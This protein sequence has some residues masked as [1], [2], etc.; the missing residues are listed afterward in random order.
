MAKKDKKGLEAELSLPRLSDV[1]ET[2][3]AELHAA[4]I[5]VA[6]EAIDRFTNIFKD[7][8]SR[9]EHIVYPAMLIMAFAFAFG[10]FLMF[11]LSNDMRR[12]S[13]GF[14]P[15]MGVHMTS[16]V[17]S[18]EKLSNSIHAMQQEMMIIAKVMQRMDKKLTAMGELT[19]MSQQVRI[20]N[21]RMLVMNGHM[22]G[23]NRQMGTMNARMGRM[24]HSVARMDNAVGRPMSFV[25]S[26]MPW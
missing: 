16:L 10:F 4:Q 6:P 3:E 13:E 25:N 12:I 21:Q 14:D 5:N 9:W 26:F 18:V 7:A 2:G 19:V 8:L 22:E 17:D 20:M 24:T 15:D 23:M 1:T 11:N